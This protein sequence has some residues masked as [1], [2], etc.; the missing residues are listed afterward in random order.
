MNCI[1][2]SIIDFVAQLI[3]TLFIME[4]SDSCIFMLGGMVGCIQDDNICKSGFP[5]HGYL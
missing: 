5:K 4:V 2:F 1:K 3:Y